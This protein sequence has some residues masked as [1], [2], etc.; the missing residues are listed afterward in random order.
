M[1]PF[2]F[3]SFFTNWKIKSLCVF[4]FKFPWS[5][6]TTLYLAL[7]SVLFQ[8]TQKSV[9]RNFCQQFSHDNWYSS[10]LDH[11]LQDSTTRIFFFFLFFCS[12]LNHLF[13][14]FYALP[15]PPYIRASV[16]KEIISTPFYSSI[17]CGG[18][19]FGLVFFSSFLFA[20]CQCFVSLF[21]FSLF[22][23]SLSILVSCLLLYCS[24]F[25][26]G[27]P[28]IPFP[29]YP[30]LFLFFLGEITPFL[31]PQFVGVFL[32]ISSLFLLLLSIPV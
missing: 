1:F 19:S 23:F 2:Q 17:F 16:D 26:V 8:F 5:C 21:L 18:D 22:F 14:Q 27:F 31:W 6:K 30:P 12:L 13:F 20:S 25:I 3:C 29:N 24:F 32:F 9:P 10:P 11:S 28:L 15:H 7:T 4:I